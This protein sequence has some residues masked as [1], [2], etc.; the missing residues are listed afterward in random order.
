MPNEV[1]IHVRGD[2]KQAEES[3]SSL[4]RKITGISN[5]VTNLIAGG[6][7][8]MIGKSFYDAFADAERATAQ[9]NAELKSTQGVAGVTA[10]GALQLADA[11]AQLSGMDDEAIL[12]AENLLL[13]F[14]RIGGEIF[15]QTTQAVL[16]MSVAMGQDLK[17]SAIQVGKALNEPVEGA[18][19][20]RRVGVQLTN[21]QEALIKKMVESGDVMGAQKIILAELET[22]FGGAAEAAGNTLPGA[23]GTLRTAFGNIQETMMGAVLPAIT[24]I[25]QGFASWL[26]QAF[27][28]TILSLEQLRAV[29][30]T[31]LAQIQDKT[32]DFLNSITGMARVMAGMPVIGKFFMFDKIATGASEAAMTMRDHAMNTREAAKAQVELANSVAATIGQVETSIPVMHGQGAALENIEKTAKKAKSALQELEVSENT[33]RKAMEMAEFSTDEQRSVLEALGV[34]A[35]DAGPHIEGLSIT[36]ERLAAAFMRAGLS[37]DAANDAIERIQASIAKKEADRLAEI[38]KR[39]QEKADAEAKRAAEEA[40][41]QAEELERR[42][43]N[44]GEL[45]SGAFKPKG[46]ERFVANVM[47]SADIIT[48]EAKAV[49]DD[50]RRQ[51]FEFN[52]DVALLFED[53]K[54]AGTQGS[55]DAVAK[56]KGI[57]AAFEALPDELQGPLGDIKRNLEKMLEDFKLTS[58]G[59]V[60]L[61]SRNHA[62]MVLIEQ[63]RIDE[64]KR[65]QKQEF[66]AKTE[67]MLKETELSQRLAA[68]QDQ[69][70]ITKR[71][72]L[73]EVNHSVIA[74]GAEQ[75]L[76]KRALMESRK[77]EREARGEAQ[78]GILQQVLGVLGFGSGPINPGME[79]TLLA[80]LQQSGLAGVNE[81][82]GRI[83]DLLEALM[84]GSLKVEMDGAIVG[85]VVGHK[86]QE[87]GRL[88]AAMGGY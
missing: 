56:I 43:L 44:I 23:L 65:V 19:A 28:Q 86:Q 18:A 52:R 49:L 87:R 32:A 64:L 72:L 35:I 8:A 26:P 4:T 24:P 6:M 20:L 27:A 47:G 61:V 70:T 50:W 2:T 9:L 62:Q 53:L 15:P 78:R 37:I 73:A 67:A 57:I 36:A 76:R 45:M 58:D 46:F 3:I 25:V 10:E 83:L 80:G 75:E 54:R 88:L 59:A 12:G 85:R 60:D 31:I 42:T 33:L 41:Q 74:L 30:L 11:M 71:K 39:E 84:S 66:D 55:T 17:S 69:E 40:Q 38:A 16:N 13:T 79:N 7:I 29:W 48:D 81:S 82:Q 22:E 1:V 34:A 51:Y 63:E 5:T 68:A 14:T 77:A 21:S